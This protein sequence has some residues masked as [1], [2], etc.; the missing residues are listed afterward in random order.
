MILLD[1]YK[2][3][4]DYYANTPANMVYKQQYKYDA[5]TSFE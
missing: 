3:V 4:L 1:N 5:G 2:D